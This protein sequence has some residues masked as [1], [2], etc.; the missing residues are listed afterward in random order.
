MRGMNDSLSPR[1]WLTG[2]PLTGFALPSGP[3]AWLQG[4]ALLLNRPE[5]REVLQVVD[6]RPGQRVVEVG[7]GPGQLLAWMADRGAYVI[8]VEPSAAMTNQAR[9]CLR[10]RLRSGQA[11]LRAG[12]AEDT[13]LPDAS[14]D[15]AVS[16]NNIPIWSDL[17]RGFQE[18]FRVL[19]PGG[20]LV[21]AWHGGRQ[22]IP[23]ARRRVLPA[24]ARDRILDR[25]RAR[26]GGGECREGRRV[27]LFE[28]TRPATP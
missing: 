23:T 15:T 9:H 26:F 17:D 7:H 8:G 10:S 14:V 21:V 18:L 12:T 1:S 19:R 22:P 3:L 2:A 6:P 20:R 5:Q 13:G 24:S 11:E 27:L 4:W 25:L 28:A 16:V